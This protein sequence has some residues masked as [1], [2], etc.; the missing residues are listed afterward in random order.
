MRITFALIV[1][2]VLSIGNPSLSAQD[3]DQSPVQNKDQVP[4]P[5][6]Q[7]DEPSGSPPKNLP[8]N[9][10]TDGWKLDPSRAKTSMREPTPS[11]SEISSS[12]STNSRSRFFGPR[13]GSRC[14]QKRFLRV[15]S[16]VHRRSSSRKQNVPIV[17]TRPCRIRTRWGADFQQADEDGGLSEEDELRCTM[18]ALFLGSTRLRSTWSTEVMASASFPISRATDSNCDP[19]ILSLHLRA[20]WSRFVWSVFEKGGA[21]AP[22]EERPAVRYLERVERRGRSNASADEGD[23]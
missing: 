7:T 2:V 17:Q 22:L 3:S 11:G 13:P 21:T 5:N 4:D 12:E 6:P 16:V 14:S 10:P 18:E 15:W 9:L 23:R 8:K 1:V 19:I 20:V